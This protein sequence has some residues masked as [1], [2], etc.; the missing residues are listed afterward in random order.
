MSKQH[1]EDGSA[2][3]SYFILTPQLVWAKVESPFEYTLWDV[4]KMIAGE[5]GE[6]WL[7]TRDLA[8]A[9]MMSKSQVQRCRQSLIDKGLLIGSLH[10]DPGHD[11]AV[12]H[13]QIPDLWAE[14][15][16]WRTANH[17]LKDRIQAKAA[18]AEGVPGGD[19]G[20]P[21]VPPKK[22]QE[23]TTKKEDP[24]LAGEAAAARPLFQDGEHDGMPLVEVYDGDTQYSCPWSDCDDGEHPLPSKTRAYTTPCGHPLGFMRDG[25]VWIKPKRPKA[26]ATPAR[27]LEHLFDKCNPAYSNLPYKR[28]HATKLLKVWQDDQGQQELHDA[29]V[30]A[31]SKGI[32]RHLK[33]E[34]ALT[35]AERVLQASGHLNRILHGPSQGATRERTA[36]SVSTERTDR[37][38]HSSIPSRL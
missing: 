23:R 35:R 1:L 37:S 13:L 16:E 4:V 18:Q 27:T 31:V 28:E 19:R 5:D 25:Q 30:W 2:D 14:N 10:R 34:R 11:N 17:S 36:P 29:L 24:P 26:T 32:A 6:C 9:S 7:S 21:G 8:I 20:V 12:W 15:V 33:V 38:R 3:K 22:N